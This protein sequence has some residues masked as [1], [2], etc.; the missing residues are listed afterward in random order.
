MREI[1]PPALPPVL[2]VGWLTHGVGN[3]YYLRRW[4]FIFLG[5]F[6]EGKKRRAPEPTDNI[7]KFERPARMG[8]D[9]GIDE[10]APRGLQ[11]GKSPGLVDTHEARVA[12]HIG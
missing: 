1:D 8:R 9:Q 12:N 4:R 5:M 3:V 11:T 10:V 6:W 2:I 7:H